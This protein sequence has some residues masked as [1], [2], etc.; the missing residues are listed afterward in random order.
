[1]KQLNWSRIFLGG[2][3]AGLVMNVVDFLTNFVLLGAAW[4]AEGDA[5]NAAVMAKSTTTA[6]VGWITFDLV[7]GILLVWLYAAIRGHFGPGPKTAMLAGFMIWLITH[8]AFVSFAFTGLYSWPL[9]LG[10]SLGGL[11]AALAGG[12]VGGMLYRDPT[13]SMATA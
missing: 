11:V 2:I 4:K 7:A 3:A 8:I 12:Y 10:S 5:L 1:M 13:P 9:V 6:M